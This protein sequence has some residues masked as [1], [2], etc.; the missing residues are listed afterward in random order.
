VPA[1]NC[2]NDMHGPIK[3]AESLRIILKGPLSSLSRSYLTDTA[4]GRHSVK[5]I[6]RRWLSGT[7]AAKR[8]GAHHVQQVI[9]LAQSNQLVFGD[10]V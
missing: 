2:S 4:S 3:S 10:I 7:V 8:R 6:C 9:V 5:N 1:K